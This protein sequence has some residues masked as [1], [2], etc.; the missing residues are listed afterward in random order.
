M[1][2]PE[3]KDKLLA[4]T[5]PMYEALDEQGSP[6]VRAAQSIGELPTPEDRG[7]ALEAATLEIARR[8]KMDVHTRIGFGTPAYVAFGLT[9]QQ[10]KHHPQAAVLLLRGDALPLEICAAP[11]DAPLEARL[12]SERPRC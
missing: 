5:G 6:Y 12:D 4:L 8:F 7:K 11:P 3:A 2:V 10:A 1:S 9:L